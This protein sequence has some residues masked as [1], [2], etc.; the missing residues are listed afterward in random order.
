VGEL[1]HIIS[2][3]PQSKTKIKNKIRIEGGGAIISPQFKK[4]K[5]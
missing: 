4:N 5:I 2:P 3:S 1:P